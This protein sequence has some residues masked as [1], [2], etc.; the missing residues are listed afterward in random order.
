MKKP[1]L[2]ISYAILLVFVCFSAA[3]CGTVPQGKDADKY[4]STFFAMDTVMEVTV[5]GDEK[6]L[7]EAENT[8]KRLESLFSVTDETSDIYILNKNGEADVSA[9]TCELLSRALDLCKRAEGVLDITV[10]P[11]VK[12]WGFTTQ[13]YRVPA[14][15]ELRALL[16]NVD[17]SK[18]NVSEG[19]RVTIPEGVTVDL[20]SVAKGYTGDRL[21]GLFK[22]NGVKSA[23]INLGGNVRALGS[24]PDG[25]AWKVAIADPHGGSNYAGV[26]SV[27]DKNVI[28]SGAYERYFER[29][30]H[31]Y[32]H[33]IDTST[34]Y[35][36]D[37]GFLSVSVIGEDG[38]LCDAFST[39]LFAMGPEKAY[40]FWK[41]SS[42]FEAIFITSDDRI[43]ITEGIKDDFTPLGDYSGKKAEVLY[44]D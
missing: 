42:D 6:N 9:E 18:V 36:A 21:V 24:K 32:H 13:E 23:L 14:E 1:L 12:A 22:E 40:D 29:D 28:T 37:N 35:P 2:L 16:G 15:T 3:G 41:K 4:T 38:V 44:H 30:G 5:Y 10:Y 26:V 31:R 27:T 25:S 43:I 11:I 7:K 34:G 19:G 33:I 39:A 20:G 8:V 17:F